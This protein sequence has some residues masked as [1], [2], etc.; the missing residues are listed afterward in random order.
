MVA[1]RSLMASK[2]HTLI[3][4]G[5]LALAIACCVLIALFVRDE[6]TFDRFHTRAGRIFRVYS[7]EVSGQAIIN[8]C[9]PFP[10]GPALKDQL[11]EVEHMSRVSKLNTQVKT[12]TQVFSEFITITSSSFLDIF[13]FE[14]VQGNREMALADVSSVAI[15]EQVAHKYFGTA[16]ALGRTVSIQLGERFEEFT[17]KAVIKDPPPNSSIRFRLIIND[18]NY[19]KLYS[20][21]RLT[22]AWFNT[23][24]ETYV[25]LREGT[26]PARV[27][28][29]FPAVFRPLVGP[30]EFDR[31]H[32]TVGL[33]PLTGIHL[34]TS[35]PA[36]IADI[37][38]PRYTYILSAVALLILTAAC[39]NFVTLSIGQSLRRAKEV[40]VRKVAGA[41]RR[42]VMMQ[43]S[44]EALIITALALAAGLVLSILCLPLFNDLADKQLA[45]HA[46]PFLLII[47]LGLAFVIA[48]LAGSYPAFVLSGFKPVVIFKGTLPAGASRQN[49]RR[50]LVGIQLVL[51]IGLMAGTLLMRD[52]LRLLQDKN[53]G[54][55]R[56][57]L[58]VV[59]LQVPFTGKLKERILT[60]FD[61]A[62]AFKTELAKLNQVAGVATSSHEFGEGDWMDV[63]FTD[64]KGVYRTFFYNTVDE[65]YLGTLKMQLVAGRNFSPANAADRRRAIIVNEAFVK[66]YGWDHALGRQLPGTKFEGHEVIGVVRDFHF[67]SLYTRIA[68]LVLAM[69]PGVIF[70]GIENMNFGSSPNPKVLIRIRPGH[71]AQTLEQ[72]ETVWKT[73]TGGDAFNFSFAD[74]A[75]DAQYRNDRHLGTMVSIATLLAMVIGSLGLYGLAALAM[76]S[77]MRE[78]S[79]RKV[80][81]ATEQS[82]LVLLSKD[83]V[84]LVGL[85]LV[86]SVPLIWWAMNSWLSTF[87]YRISIGPGAFAIAG[88]TSLLIALLTISYQAIKT[89]WSQPANTLKS[90]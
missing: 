24:P 83:Y 54:F 64:D 1:V 48:M 70:N 44:A 69:D 19:P 23:T 36:A 55:D 27:T 63:G 10:M 53:L 65:N 45:L 76:Q 25:L 78:I 5:G 2:A 59:P 9:T 60:G 34:D 66:A 46:G 30:E 89:A 61:K 22:S 51:S 80:L 82:L 6:L 42:Q 90:E 40:A 87:E 38:N 71:T 84:Y 72:I 50:V 41:Q 86:V 58:V 20:A 13:D 16:G 21:Q 31:S 68:P 14:V 75:I 77:R 57:Q 85:A 4:T 81:G 73:V 11:Q 88:A 79:I 56:E 39:I 67:A 35:F 47:I 8:T 18:L 3:N 43:F 26:D 17:V 29:K 28:A 62:Q 15:T 52:Q 49:L 12:D 74:Q 32:Y 33:Q 37:S 7:T